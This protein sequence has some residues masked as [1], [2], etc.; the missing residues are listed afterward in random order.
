M[1]EQVHGFSG[2]CYKKFRSYDESFAAF[3]SRNNSI[4]TLAAG[5]DFP[6]QIP[7]TFASSILVKS[8]VIVLLLIYVCVL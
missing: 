7:A 1:Q 2:A 3:N 8:V 6:Q 5:G 4:P